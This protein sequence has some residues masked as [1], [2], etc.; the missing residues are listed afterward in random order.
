M[1]N[2]GRKA[3]FDAIQHASFYLDDLRIY[4]DT[5]SCDQKALAT[6]NKVATQRSELVEE[7]VE[8][9]GPLTFYDYNN[10]CS[11]WLWVDAPWPW[12]GGCN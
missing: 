7:Y 11:D 4:L 3:L 1:G 9:F 6:Y 12:E 8:K 2:D 10:S 5:H